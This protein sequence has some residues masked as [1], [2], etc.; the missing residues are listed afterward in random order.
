MTTTGD[1]YRFIDG[2][3]P[4]RTAMSF[5]NPGLLVGDENTEVTAAVLSL[6][7][8]PEVVLEASGLGAQLVISHHPVIFHPLK[9]LSTNSVPYLL[10]GSSIAAIC[11]HTNLDMAPGGVND[12]L[13][14]R[15][16]LKN[17]RMLRENSACG[18]AEALCG[19]TD[20]EYG[21]R[22]FAE[23]VKNALGCEG[24]RFTDGKK[25]ITSVGLCGGGG[26]EYLYDAA[27]A[28]CQAFVT[29]EC[30]HNILLDA[31]SLG[32][33]MVEAGHFETEDPVIPFLMQ[34]L[35]ERFQDVRFIRSGAM[36]GPAHYL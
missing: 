29:G 11:A 27:Q 17:V 30:K 7:I 26:A 14:E 10:A 20:R 12:C 32:V 21:P 28:G 35:G 3:A 13:A 18:L 9:K 15:L 4:F 8:T 6:D 2:F 5:D 23:F 34:K 19:E 1:I 24:V 25:R 31:E 22:E 36:H 16:R 33:T